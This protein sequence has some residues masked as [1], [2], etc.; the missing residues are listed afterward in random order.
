MASI[1][2][3]IIPV[4][5][6]IQYLDFKTEAVDKFLFVIFSLIPHFILISIF[7]IKTL[8]SGNELQIEE[9]QVSVIEYNNLDASKSELTAFMMEHKPYIS[10][11]L[12]LQALAN[13]ICWNRSRLSMVINK[14]FDKNFYDF[15]NEYRLNAVLEKLNTGTYKDY[16]LDYIVTECGFKSY[17]SFYRI[18]KRVKNKSPKEYL[19]HLKNQ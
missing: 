15:V 5:L 19:K 2:I 1:C 6:L 16:S 3:I 13:L 11:D 14:G 12:N 7:S 9:K 17:V 8:E 18:F 4:S 10:Q